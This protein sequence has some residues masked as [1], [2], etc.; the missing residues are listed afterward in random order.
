MTLRDWVDMN[1]MNFAKKIDE[2]KGEEVMQ[3]KATSGVNVND[4]DLGAT[5]EE[6]DAVDGIRDDFSFDTGLGGG[7]RKMKQTLSIRIGMEL[8]E[9]NRIKWNGTKK[10]ATEADANFTDQT[11]KNIIEEIVNKAARNEKAA[12]VADEAARNDKAATEAGANITNQI[13]NNIVEEIVTKEYKSRNDPVWFD[14][15]EDLLQSEYDEF[16]YPSTDEEQIN[17]VEHWQDVAMLKQDMAG[18]DIESCK[19]KQAYIERLWDEKEEVSKKYKKLK[20]KMK[21]IQKV[22]D[23]DEEEAKEIRK[24]RNKCKQLMMIVQRIEKDEEANEDAAAAPPVVPAHATAPTNEPRTRSAIK[25]I[26][27]RTDRKEKQLEGFEVQK[28]SKKQRKKSN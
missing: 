19:R 17:I 13:L 10:T 2:N 20:I 14:E 6:A 11:L 27:E 25:R 9:E 1:S 26:K 28:P 18:S 7:G 23:K 15:W 22:E 21:K 3:T 8:K 4:M 5:E 24:W 16:G 12:T